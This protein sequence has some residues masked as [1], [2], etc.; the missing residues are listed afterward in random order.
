M[1]KTFL[2]SLV[3]A[4][5]LVGCGDSIKDAAAGVADK[6]KEA[7]GKLPWWYGWKLLPDK[8]KA[9]IRHR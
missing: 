8:E 7:V 9:C 4:A 5:F 1:K 6:A 2:Y 3:V